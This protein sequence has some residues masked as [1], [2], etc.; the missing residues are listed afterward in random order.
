MLN[1]EM[2]GRLEE[3]VVNSHILLIWVL[4]AGSGHGMIF[5][6]MDTLGML[7]L[8]YLLLKYLHVLG[9]VLLL[10]V[11]ELLSDILAISVVVL[12]RR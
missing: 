3:W 9:V 11:L 4:V 6:L 7:V 8:R 2:G 12:G 10:Q 5:S 1:V